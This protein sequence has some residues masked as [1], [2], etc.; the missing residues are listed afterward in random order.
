M[1]LVGAH[2]SLSGNPHITPTRERGERGVGGAAYLLCPP[3][4]CGANKI[5]RDGCAGG[6]GSK[7]PTQTTQEAPAH[8]FKD[9]KRTDRKRPPP[10]PRPTPQEGAPRRSIRPERGNDVEIPPE[11]GARQVRLPKPHTDWGAHHLPYPEPKRAGKGRQPPTEDALPRK[12]GGRHATEGHGFTSR[13]LKPPRSTLRCAASSQ[14][15]G[16]DTTSTQ[17]PR[18]TDFAVTLRRF[19]PPNQFC[20]G[21]A[22]RHLPFLCLEEKK[23]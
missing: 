2:L 6:N 8:H 22:C 1:K 18:R 12:G 17:T 10:L 5:T 20:H 16:V 14:T 3:Y 21:T 11:A 9:E 19:W 4:T 23:V 15:G 13:T 7:P